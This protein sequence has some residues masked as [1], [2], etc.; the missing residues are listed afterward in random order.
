MTR[1]RALSLAFLFAVT[2]APAARAQ[3]IFTYAGGGSDDGRPAAQAA[4]AFPTGIALDAAGNLYV[5]DTENQRIRRVDRATGVISTVAGNG[6]ASSSGD[7]RPAWG[8]SLHTPT[9]LAFD[10]A[11]N[12]YVCELGAHVVRKID[13][14]TQRISTVAGNGGYG[15]GGDGGPA[16]QAELMEPWALARDARGTSSSRTPGRT[17]CVGSPSRPGRSRRSPG[18]ASPRPQET[19]GPRRAPR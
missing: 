17:G 7:G 14:A 11:G 16:L 6:A 3:T 13:A 8:A 1:F 15:S 9:G 2:T 4:L 18:T 10:R 19:A 5:A 12:L